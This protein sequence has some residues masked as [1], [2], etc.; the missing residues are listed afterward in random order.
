MSHTIFHH[1]FIALR[2]VILNSL[3]LTIWGAVFLL[4][5]FF[6]TELPYPVNY[7]LGIPLMV[8]GLLLALF[9]VYEIIVGVF[10]WQYGKTHCPWCEAETPF[11]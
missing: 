8:V 6:W 1:L 5:L 2:S 11:P 9:S 4:G 10:S 7:M 3:L